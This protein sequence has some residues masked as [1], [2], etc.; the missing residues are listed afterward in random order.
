MRLRNEQQGAG[1]LAIERRLLQLDK[2]KSNPFWSHPETAHLPEFTQRSL[3]DAAFSRVHN[4]ND[5]IHIV[6]M[7][8]GFVSGTLLVLSTSC[9]GLYIGPRKF[10]S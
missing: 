3:F 5:L 10:W 1:W 7:I 4:D 6:T 9:F 8:V 2:K